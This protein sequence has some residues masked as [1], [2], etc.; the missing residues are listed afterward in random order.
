M[1]NKA[2]FCVFLWLKRM[3]AVP[4]SNGEIRFTF[5]EI[6]STKVYVRKNKTFF[7]KRTQFQ[8]K[9]NQ[10]NRFINKDIRSNGHLVNSEKRT[11][12]EPNFSQ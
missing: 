11:Q 1:T 6:R 10:R 7:A 3:P 5:H 12:N 9:S 2:P 4:A 8:K